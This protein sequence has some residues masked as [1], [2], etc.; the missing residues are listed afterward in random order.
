MKDTLLEA[1]KESATNY[2]ESEFKIYRGPSSTV[3]SLPVRLTILKTVDG[4][5][6]KF[7][8]LGQTSRMMGYH[9]EGEGVRDIY[10]KIRNMQYM[11]EDGFKYEI[12]QEKYEETRKE[13]E[14]M[15]EEYLLCTGIGKLTA[16]MKP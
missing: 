12:E 3:F 6:S 7:S 4:W 8:L 5:M 13:I 10:L 11:E 1:L 2:Y 16:G 14:Q 15:E 9:I